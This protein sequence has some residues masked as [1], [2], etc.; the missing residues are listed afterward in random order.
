MMIS[1]TVTA[2]QSDTYRIS[3]GGSVSSPIPKLTSAGRLSVNPS[4]AVEQTPPKIGD[5]VLCWFPGDAF[6]DGCVVGIVE[7]SG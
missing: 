4:G 5:E 2:I 7:G 1:G 3:I 6:C